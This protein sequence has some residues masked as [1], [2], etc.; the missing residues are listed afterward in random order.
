MFTALDNGQ[1]VSVFAM[2]TIVAAIGFLL[3]VAYV[4]AACGGAAPWIEGELC[5]GGYAWL[6]ALATVYPFALLVALAWSVLS[7]AGRARQRVRAAP[8]G[9]WVLNRAKLLLDDGTL[10][11]QD[12]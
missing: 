5:E 2:S 10:A 11:D 7:G 1:T 4:G 3:D 8:P 9:P 6:F 12:A